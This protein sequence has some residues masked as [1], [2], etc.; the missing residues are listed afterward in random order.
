MTELNRKTRKGQ[1]TTPPAEVIS[2]NAQENL[3]FMTTH[4]SKPG[5]VDLNIFATGASIDD[6]YRGAKKTF[7]PFSGRPELIRELAPEIKNLYSASPSTTIVLLIST[8]RW[9]WRHLDRCQDVA[10]VYSIHDLN[11]IHYAS[12]RADP[13]T[14][15]RAQMFFKL[16][17]RARGARNLPPLYWTS[18]ASPDRTVSLVP[19]EDV[20]RIYHFIKRP[21]FDALHRFEQS[22]DE[23]PS[24][25]DILRLFTLFVL[26][27][28]WNAS[29]ALDIDI[30]LKD[31]DGKLRCILPHPQNNDFCYVQSRKARAAGSVQYALSRNK[32]QIS[33]SNIVLALYRQTQP[34]R[35][36]LSRYLL[37]LRWQLKRWETQG[38]KSALEI[39]HRKV[40]IAEVVRDI[41]SPWL[42]TKATITPGRRR[43]LPIQDI[44]ALQK[45]V[46]YAGGRTIR[47]PLVVWGRQIN[48]ELQ[49][50]ERRIAE[51]IQL[52]DLRDAYISW[53]W[54]RSGYS[55][56]DAM[57]AAG[58][59]SLNTLQKYLNKKQHKAA[60]RRDF[61]K[62]GDALWEAIVQVNGL[63][64]STSLTTVVAAK[65]AG[66]TNEQIVRW[67]KSKD[68]T[69]VGT[70]CADF[71]NPPKNYSK[72]LRS[73]DGCRFQRCTLC[74]NAILLPDG[75]HHLA[76]RYVELNWFHSSISQI[77]WTQSDY[78][79]ELEN[80]KA[81]LSMYDQDKVASSIAYW[82]IEIEQGNHTVLSQEAAYA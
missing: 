14:D 11:D 35:D 79:L 42:Y 46:M 47:S 68:Q 49:P 2:I 31:E 8:L 44:S 28:G 38:G 20:R 63:N 53:R 74:E 22:P 16:V 62:V 29:T 56:L 80:T 23:T 39:N 60:S 33:P 19:Y 26:S 5:H 40:L 81:A 70:G 61:L 64:A 10:P 37:V 82:K 73:G 77:A 65:V 12:Y 67:L 27:T 58:H 66:A 78:P 17:H 13:C 43:H 24:A 57:L 75:Y 71:Y 25:I 21:A 34:L 69:Y 4:L 9:W 54:E 52:S 3:Y 55:W 51:N 15:T 50:G 45:Y 48:K 32:S 7:V 1:G 41:K 59:K 18:I 30:S 76:K 36:R 72:D 6:C